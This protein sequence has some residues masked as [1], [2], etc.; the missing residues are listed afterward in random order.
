MRTV[1]LLSLLVSVALVGVLMTSQL[2][3]THGTAKS[4][5]LAQIDQAARTGAAVSLN[6]ADGMLE[7]YQAAQ[8]T[9]AGADLTG[10]NV[11]LVRADTA[12]YCVET[13][14]GGKVFHEDGPGG[15][16]AT[17]HC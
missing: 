4:G 6:L 2:G 14:S 16:P 17:G 3:G 13:T 15:S 12:S 8:G 7:R 11:T 5:A 9:Y 1:S 10:L